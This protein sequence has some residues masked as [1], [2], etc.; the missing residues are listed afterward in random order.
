MEKSVEGI[1]RSLDFARDDRR[2][3]GMTKRLRDDRRTLEMTKR[4]LG[5][6]GI[7]VINDKILIF[8]IMIEK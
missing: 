6:T 3:L 8:R 2:T 1:N 5:M 4:M 7:P